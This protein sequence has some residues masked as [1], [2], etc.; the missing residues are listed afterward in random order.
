MT[1]SIFQSLR[2]EIINQISEPAKNYFTLYPAAEVQTNTAV[3]ANDGDQLGQMLGGT[4]TT[5]ELEIEQ[6]FHCVAII[7]SPVDGT[8]EQQLEIY[9][10]DSG[11][12]DRHVVF[13]QNISG[14]DSGKSPA[15]I[16]FD[17]DVPLFS[18]TPYN[19]SGTVRG[20]I[21]KVAHQ[22]SALNVMVIGYTEPDGI[23]PFSQ[24]ELASLINYVNYQ[25]DGNGND[26]GGDVVVATTIAT[27]GD[28]VGG[29]FAGSFTNHTLQIGQTFHC[30]G[31]I[32]SPVTPTAE[33]RLRVMAGDAG[34]PDRH[35]VFDQ[36][37]SGADN[38]ES[39]VVIFIRKDIPIFSV[40]PYNDGGT[41]R[42]NVIRAATE[43]S[44]MNVVLVGW[45]EASG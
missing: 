38:A 27:T 26:A 44:D 36:E 33:Q 1:A 16:F 31:I 43:T 9:A 30:V 28:Q 45:V 32:A 37:I 20:N 13:K 18:V 40:T 12:D 24:M 3:A 25:F 2:Q 7:A 34:D 22:T 11:D 15:V 42:A 35:I 4:F 21:L 39:P 8:A 19:H 6:T 17:G 14:S 23:S 10:G 41:T 29:W 5:M